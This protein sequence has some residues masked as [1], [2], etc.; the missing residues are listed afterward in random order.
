MKRL[1]I[2][3]ML[4][5][6]AT[7]SAQTQQGK[8]AY[9]TAKTIAHTDD[10]FGRKISDPYRWMEDLNSADLAAWV[11]AE[12]SVTE[13][14]LATL[15][16]RDRFKSRL[17]E[18]YN[19][20]RISVPF[21][22]AGRLFYNK[23]TGL[24][25]QGVWMVRTSVD[26][27]ERV[28]IDPN[29]LSPDGSIAL[30][31]F[32]PS[33]DGKLFAYGL[34]QGGSD[35]STVYVRDLATG[36]QLGDT[37]QWIKF[38]GLS[39]TKD[40]KGFFYSRFP[41]PAKGKELESALR[42]QKLYYHALGTSQSKDR[43][44][45]ERPDHP[46][47]FVSGGLT[48]DR[49]YLQIIVNIGTDPHNRLYIADLGDAMHP[50][51]GAPIKALFD[52]PDASYVPIGNVGTTLYMLTDKK[53]PKQRIVSF[54]ISRPQEASWKTIVA[55]APNAI[56]NVAMAK[57]RIAVNYLEDVKS[58]VRTFD[59]TGK[60][61][62]VL[63]F[64][65]IGALAGLSARNDSPELFYGF[66]SPLYPVTIFRYDASTSRATTFAEQKIKNFNPA[67]YETK[68]VFATSKD[69]TKVP[70]FITMRKGTKLDGSNPTIL[71]GYGG[72]DINIL[73]T[74]SS[75][76]I[77]WI[78]Q[79][80]IY[81]TA[82]MRGG[83]EYGEEWHK[84]G[85]FEKK[86]NVFDDFIAAGEYLV[87]EHYTSPA[88]L[89]IEGGSNGGLLVGAVEEQRPDLFAV[90]LPAVG[91][92]D[93]L[94]YDKFTGG[95][96]WAAEYGSSSDSTAFKYLI[97]YS[98]VQNVKPGTCYPATLLT[99]ADHDDRVV[100]S[101]TFKLTALMQKAQA[102]DKPILVRVETQGSHGYRST[103]KAIA[104]AADLWAF[105][106]ANMG[107]KPVIVP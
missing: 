29:V 39:W 98:P 11:K 20:V 44:I 48:D 81:A 88:K 83:S 49:R 22:E 79:G 4:G 91:V 76:A 56:D 68:Q 59:L 38:S 17:T 96:A 52:T 14:Y 10:Y 33:P 31:Q 70:V 104:E 19:R 53:A 90:A 71:Y 77:A 84:A 106:A 30:S 1:L 35:W 16:M 102:C 47:W 15:P 63:A 18:L 37:V 105:A 9:P 60:P 64:P 80:G 41:T 3:A 85:M 95:Q 62:G 45:Y 27:P 6:T 67:L 57:D 5:M 12:N 43:L 61:A 78:E 75:N 82:N 72:F 54:D 55:E 8:V 13:R 89:G 66:T 28:V 93:M 92:M 51:I 58:T 99:T 94:R 46:D 42:N 87:K 65:G 100:P 69:G 74:Y 101:H 86:Q 107:M 7:L 40:G 97:K 103:D 73:P 50:N 32:A 2:C 23:N 36:K 34:S 26:G 21:R 25:P 24:Q